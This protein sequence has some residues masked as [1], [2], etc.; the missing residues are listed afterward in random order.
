MKRPSR[1]KVAYVASISSCNEP[2]FLS[3]LVKSRI[4]ATQISALLRRRSGA[5]SYVRQA[6][7]DCRQSYSSIPLVQILGQIAP[8]DPL[9]SLLPV[10]RVP[11][12]AALPD[13]DRAEQ[14]VVLVD[15]DLDRGAGL[16]D[17]PGLDRHVDGIARLAPGSACHACHS[18]CAMGLV[19]RHRLGTPC[20]RSLSRPEG[21]AIRAARTRACPRS[22]PFLSCF[23]ALDA[24]LSNVGIRGK[25][26]PETV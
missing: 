15:C 9:E 11:V 22:R 12:K 14:H 3:F 5:I 24:A 13:L 25:I 20:W 16:G 21:H 7:Q 2:R 19:S 10:R 4:S 6:E 23:R 8:P 26:A 1:S 18:L 17:V